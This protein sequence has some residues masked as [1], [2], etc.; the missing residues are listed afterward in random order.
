LNHNYGVFLC[1]YGH[2][3]ASLPLFRA[4]LAAASYA[5]RANS[6]AALGSCLLRLARG[7]EARVQFDLALAADPANPAA[8]FALAELD[9]QSGNLSAARAAMQRHAQLRATN[10]EA[11]WLS[12]RI[13]HRLG[14]QIEK[15]AFTHALEDLFPRS[16]EAELCAGSHF[17]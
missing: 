14:N 6:H 10:P 13:A 1:R 8:L 5:R 3:A 4:A 2:V 15:N 12:L 17:D 16:H 7:D 9:Y 11:L